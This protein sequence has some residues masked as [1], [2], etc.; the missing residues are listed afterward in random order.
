VL[1]DG[2]HLGSLTAHRAACDVAR[3]ATLE[4]GVSE[5]AVDVGV[6]IPP[7]AQVPDPSDHRHG[8]GT[9]HTVVLLPGNADTD[10]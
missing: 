3:D 2:G 8:R 10:T 6:E 1:D 7:V 9:L 4:L 5:L